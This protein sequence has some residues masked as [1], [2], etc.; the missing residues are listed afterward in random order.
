MQV[1]AIIPTFRRPDDLRK[2]LDGLQAQSRLPD[3]VVVVVRDIDEPTARLLEAYAPVR[4]TIKRVVVRE[5]GQVAALNCALDAASGDILAI[6]DDDTIPKP[7]WIARIHARFEADPK[8]G[9]L[10]GPDWIATGATV[11][12]GSIGVCGKMQWFGRLDCSECLSTQFCEVDT[13]KGCN[14]TYR[15]TAIGGVRFDTRLAGEGAQ[16]LNDHAFALAV[17]RRGWKLMYDRELAIDHYPAAKF[18]YENRSSFVPAAHANYVHNNTLLVLRHLPLK[19]RF[20]FLFY[21]FLIGSKPMPGLAEL[22]LRILRKGNNPVR[23]WWSTVIGRVRGI[24][25]FLKVH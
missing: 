25:T 18:D 24:R 3:E 12:D 17:R 2:C 21:A 19:G 10:G 6:T 4:L 8:L 7:N 23:F 22:P 16:V 20:A 13:L 14:M 15:R 5:G 11:V 9:G 1:S